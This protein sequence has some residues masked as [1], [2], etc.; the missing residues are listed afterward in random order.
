MTELEETPNILEAR[1]LGANTRRTAASTPR[2]P[3]AGEQLREVDEF[4][5]HA[6]IEHGD[7][8]SLTLST[9]TSGLTHSL[10]RFPAK[11]IPQVPRWAVNNF[12]T[13]GSVVYDPFMGSGTTL[14]EA[15]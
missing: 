11:Y 12:A 13:A 6:E 3:A 8:L 7:L 5:A 10:H 9:N 14:V 1:S 4:P 2:E 15:L